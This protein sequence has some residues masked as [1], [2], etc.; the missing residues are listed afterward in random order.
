M[1]LALGQNPGYVNSIEC[2]KSF[3]TMASFFYICEY[4]GV[5][6][7]EFFDSSME[8]PTQIN[9]TM[10][11]VKMLNEEQLVHVCA[12]VEDPSKSNTG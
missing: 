7:M 12:I 3:P 2:G 1:S 11:S 6:P 4:L 8:S 9:R 5:T 10:A